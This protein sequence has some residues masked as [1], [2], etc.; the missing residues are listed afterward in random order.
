MTEQ[1]DILYAISDKSTILIKPIKA[2]DTKVPCYVIRTYCPKG[3][4]DNSE[5]RHLIGS[6][7]QIIIPKR[8]AYDLW[9]TLQILVP[10][11]EDIPEPD[12]FFGSFLMPK[13]SHVI[14]PCEDKDIITVSSP[15]LNLFYTTICKLYL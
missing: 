2:K 5:D 13:G 11:I 9:R 10:D 4:L 12:N 6:T 14:F 1:E 8:Y 7:A 15:P 3:F